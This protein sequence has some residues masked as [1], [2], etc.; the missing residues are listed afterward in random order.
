MNLHG[1]KETVRNKLVCNLVVQDVYLRNVSLSE[2]AEMYFTH[3]ITVD[4][5]SYMMYS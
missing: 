2:T 1:F 4:L 3:H 5:R